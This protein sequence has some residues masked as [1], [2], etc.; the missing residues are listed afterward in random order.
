MHINPLNGVKRQDNIKFIITVRGNICA[1]MK[2]KR[3]EEY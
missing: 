1:K 2:M 3:G